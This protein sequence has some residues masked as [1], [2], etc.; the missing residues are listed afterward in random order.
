MKPINAVALAY[1]LPESIFIKEALLDGRR[2]QGAFKHT[3]TAQD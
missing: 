1:F 3:L 2:D